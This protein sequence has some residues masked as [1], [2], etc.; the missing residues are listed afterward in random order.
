MYDTTTW[1]RVVPANEPWNGM[2]KDQVW[3]NMCRIWDKPENAVVSHI[4]AGIAQLQQRGLLT[5]EEAAASLEATI[6]ARRKL[7]R[8]AIE[9]H[10]P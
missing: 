8:T 3:D 10:L 1:S 2:T 6:K 5:S 7:K 4:K 9:A